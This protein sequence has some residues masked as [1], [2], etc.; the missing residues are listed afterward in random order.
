[1]KKNILIVPIAFLFFSWVTAFAQDS[2]DQTVIFKNFLEGLHS[3]SKG[4]FYKTRKEYKV[5]INY[6]ENAL[7][8][9]AELHR[10]YY[11]MADCYYRLGDFAK[12]AKYASLSVEQRR[13]YTSA[14]MVLYH[15]NMKL[16]NYN[17]AS[18]ALQ[19][20][21]QEN[22][23]NIKAHFLLGQLYFSKIK[24]IEKAASYF[25][26][27]VT[28]SKEQSLDKTY[29]ETSLYYL[30][31]LNYKKGNIENAV[32]HLK[33]ALSVN[34]RNRTARRFLI[35]ILMAN[36]WLDEAEKQINTYVTIFP[37][38][39]KMHSY[40][41]R[42]YYLRNDIKAVF[43]LRKAVEQ[44]NYDGLLAKALLME[45]SNQGDDAE[46]ILKLIT[47]KHKEYIC[48][49]VA[50]AKIYE[51]KKDFHSALP[52]YLTAAV[53]FYH[54]ALYDEAIRMFSKVL[55]IREGIAEVYTYL[56][57]IYEEK[58]TLPVA[59]LYYKKSNE[60]QANSKLL[61]HMGYL[62]LTIKNYSEALKCLDLAIALE[63]SD[64]QS[65]FLKGITYSHVGKYHKAESNL[66]KAV[67]LKEDDLYFY[68]LA[69]VQEK[70]HKIKDTIKSL[71]RA[72][73]LNP[74]NSRAYN[75]LGYLYAERNM[76]LDESVKLIQ[77][78]LELEPENGAYLDSLGWAYFRQRKYKE[79][80][81]LLHR[82]EKNLEKEGI[83][84][85][86]VYDHIG[87]V[88]KKLGKIS[89]AIK[90]W[91]KAYKINKTVEIKRKL[92]RHV[93]K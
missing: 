72:I 31:Y 44:M 41:G 27:I 11:N 88:Y 33:E 52:E 74:N 7:K 86:V 25:E 28:I 82:A 45:L 20:L 65:Y 66:R 91:E 12:A 49:H 92:E 3:Y 78:A 77:R 67:N 56:G 42:I 37:C 36:Y 38:E 60:L 69:N 47:K 89:E 21:I 51:R 34:E 40:L 87:D 71:K 48:P 57:K 93:R 84:D 39:A 58:G 30:G 17:G 2:A 50:L 85:P 64:S 75:Y 14:Y 61:S 53:K 43:H 83:P 26:K 13:D 35:D 23:N 59:L 63:P 54:A 90:Y 68:Y 5:A 9:N 4:L 80:L 1:M 24:D 22:P 19:K 79:A 81:E 70:L 55:S 76:K 18:E 8:G 32:E 16:K 46:G 6:F 10:I 62:Y 29:Y 73:E 15:T